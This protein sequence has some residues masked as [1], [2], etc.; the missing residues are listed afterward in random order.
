M[1]AYLQVAGDAVG[2]FGVAPLVLLVGHVDLHG[3]DP[4][5]VGA[6]D[7]AVG[8]GFGQYDELALV[9]IGG[10]RD[11][12]KGHAVPELFLVGGWIN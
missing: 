5:G 11:A 1:H 9:R 4:G 3:A 10:G 7:L 12:G 8:D 6:S 2:D